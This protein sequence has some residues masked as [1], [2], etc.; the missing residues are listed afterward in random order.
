MTFLRVARDERVARDQS[1]PPH[2]SGK[3]CLNLGILGAQRRCV[4][5]QTLDVRS[6][7]IYKLPLRSRSRQWNIVLNWRIKCIGAAGVE[8][9]R[10]T[11]RATSEAR[12]KADCMCSLTQTKHRSSPVLPAHAT[13]HQGAFSH[14][15]PSDQRTAK[16][17]NEPTGNPNDHQTAKFSDSLSGSCLCGSITVT[18]ND[19]ELF[20]RPRGHLCHCANCRKVAGSYVASNLLIEA[21]KVDVKDRDG[22]LK[23]YEDKH[24]LSGNSVFRKFCSVDG[25]YDRPLAMFL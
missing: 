18:I 3:N 5:R 17:P 14:S 6:L 7:L 25:K 20:D 13:R 12:H 10:T 4:R 19:S 9:L 11:R 21:E 22:T 16:M 8:A 15:I 24:T 23:V 1:N 2:L